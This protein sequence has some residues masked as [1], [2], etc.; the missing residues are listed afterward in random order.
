MKLKLL[1]EQFEAERKA[2]T[3]KLQPKI[4]GCVWQGPSGALPDG[5]EYKFIRGETINPSECEQILCII[6][7]LIV[8]FIIPY[9]YVCFFF[10]TCAY[11]ITHIN[12]RKSLFSTH[13]TPGVHIGTANLGQLRTVNTSVIGVRGEQRRGRRLQNSVATAIRTKHKEEQVARQSFT[14]AGQRRANAKLVRS[15]IGN[16]NFRLTSV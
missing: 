9:N 5:G 15:P 14:Q 3:H 2:K 13:E 10:R 6:L 8:Y 7:F 11:L 1:G 16:V 12:K 4:I